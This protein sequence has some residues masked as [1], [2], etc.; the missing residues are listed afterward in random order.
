MNTLIK[1]I[2]IS[3]ILTYIICFL[4]SLFLISSVLY[5][6]IFNVLIFFSLTAYTFYIKNDIKDIEDNQKLKVRQSEKQFE[7]SLKNIY[8]EHIF[9]IT[10]ELRTPL[11][12]I[13][14]SL[15]NEYNNI[16]TMYSK[17]DEDD[18]F[19]LNDHFIKSKRILKNISE[20]SEQIQDFIS[21]ISEYGSYVSDKNKKV[22]N[23]KNYLMSIILNAHSYSRNMKV[24][25]QHNINF[26][27]CFGDEFSDAYT[28]V[29][30]HD[31]SRI[32]VNIITNSA[33]A[34]A[35]SYKTKK[36]KNPDY[37]PRIKIRCIKSKKSDRN[38]KLSDRFLRINPKSE[39]DSQPFYIIIED[40]GP[41]I[42][43]ENIKKIFEY[44]YSTK[45]DDTKTDEDSSNSLS[46]HK[47]L[48]LYLTL[49][50]ANSN[51]IRVY[52]KTDKNGTIF[53]LGLNSIIYNDDKV[54]LTED[55]KDLYNMFVVDESNKSDHD[56]IK[57]E[58]L[59]ALNE[60]ADEYI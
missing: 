2:I 18:K 46:L 26:G 12:V 41:G 3:N 22:I 59:Q 28:V 60:N 56:S 25:S 4:I 58:Y 51:N 14:S 37:E 7:N 54:I 6:V 48:G 36:S 27:S 42:S 34:I 38:I 17:L 49:K 5:F 53:A 9:S 8:D 1:K 31:L 10:H 29:K 11:A 24:F 32:L 20:Q 45:I 21:S 50:L 43:Q 52:I 23:L 44:G 13:T 33:D 19:K 35:E 47:G 30:P 57:T 39:R 55:C 15:H 16:K 40:N